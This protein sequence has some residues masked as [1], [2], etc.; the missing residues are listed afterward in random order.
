MGNKLSR[1]YQESIYTLIYVELT[2]ACRLLLE[3]SCQIVSYYNT[4][5]KNPFQT[6]DFHT[7]QFN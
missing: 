4:L 5:Y 2:S 3:G 6:T 7:R 1:A